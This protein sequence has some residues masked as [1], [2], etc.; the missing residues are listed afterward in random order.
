[1]L[2]AESRQIQNENKAQKCKNSC[3]LKQFTK[4]FCGLSITGNIL[5][6][7][8]CFSKLC[9]PVQTG[10]NS[11]KSHGLYYKRGQAR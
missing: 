1:L 10:I 3:S 8:G 9:A 11:G 2:E 5:I 4:G 7:I 6:E